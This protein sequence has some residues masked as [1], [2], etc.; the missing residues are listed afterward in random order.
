M[1]SDLT[2]VSLSIYILFPRL[3][4]YG[5]WEKTM[6]RFCFKLT[7]AISSTRFLMLYTRINFGLLDFKEKFLNID[8]ILALGICPIQGHCYKNK[9]VKDCFETSYKCFL[10]SL[11]FL[12][13]ITNPHAKLCQKI[14]NYLKVTAYFKRTLPVKLRLSLKIRIYTKDNWK[15]TAFSRASWWK[16][17]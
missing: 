15:V 6:S 2:H 13:F 5:C 11:L 10:K 17:D 14:S 1:Y 9:L 16:S 8:H 4:I 12:I 3:C 7:F